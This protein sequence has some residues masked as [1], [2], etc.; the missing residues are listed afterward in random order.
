M[1]RG[2]VR[3]GGHLGA[4]TLDNLHVWLDGRALYC[5]KNGKRAGAVVAWAYSA[6]GHTD[7]A[8]GDCRGQVKCH[9]SK[10]MTWPH[11]ITVP[12]R[13]QGRGPHQSAQGVIGTQLHEVEFL[14][15][16]LAHKW[17]ILCLVSAFERQFLSIHLGIL[18]KPRG[19]L[20]SVALQLAQRLR[21]L[22]DMIRSC[23][24]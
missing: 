1:V 10:H 22:A 15:Q 24:V 23:T 18:C 12:Q 13:S 20:C 9:V 16:I 2:S 11:F 7:K 17:I 19:V 14:A 6:C 3:A 4:V 8:V 21:S 5:T